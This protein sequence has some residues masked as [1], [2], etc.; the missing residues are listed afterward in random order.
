[1]PSRRHKQHSVSFRPKNVPYKPTA[2]LMSVSIAGILS[3]AGSYAWEHT[4][5]GT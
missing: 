4:I 3:K 5:P 1:M 2:T